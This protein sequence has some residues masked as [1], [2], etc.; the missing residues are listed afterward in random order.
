MLPVTFSGVFNGE[1][2]FGDA[3]PP[4][5]F[6]GYKILWKLCKSF[7]F[8][9]DKKHKICYSF[10]GTWLRP[11]T[12]LGN[13]LP[14]TLAPFLNSKYATGDVTLQLINTSLVSHL[15]IEKVC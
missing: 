1:G 2:V 12:P 13:F 10:W 8:S 15:C 3:P 11:W 14:Q 9:V 6:S 4:R 7:Y 5:P